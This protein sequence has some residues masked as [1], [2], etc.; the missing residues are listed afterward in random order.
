MPLK[1]LILIVLLVV[2]FALIYR[3]QIYSWLQ[4]AKREDEEETEEYMEDERE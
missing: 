3:E 2:V 4:N 1:G